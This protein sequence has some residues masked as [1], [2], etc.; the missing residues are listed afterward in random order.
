VQLLTKPQ[1][2]EPDAGAAVLAAQLA[3]YVEE[4]RASVLRRTL[5]ESG[6]IKTL[7]SELRGTVHRGLLSNAQPEMRTDLEQQILE[8]AVVFEATRGRQYLVRY[9][10]IVL[11]HVS[12]AAQKKIVEVATAARGEGILAELAGSL[13]ESAIDRAMNV[14]ASADPVA[15]RHGAGR[16]ADLGRIDASLEMAEGIEDDALRAAALVGVAR[17]MLG[18]AS[19]LELY[20]VWSRFLPVLARQERPR[21]LKMLG[22]TVDIM[23]ALGGE[24]AARETVAA[25][26]ASGRWWP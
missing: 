23:A 13:P 15:R 17:A 5:F 4:P 11:P 2:R 3:P 22:Q 14:L 21:L 25:I 24:A 16:L 8:S 18:R 1:E 9:L 12:E 20:E 19:P 6:V 7:G 26:D 10:Q